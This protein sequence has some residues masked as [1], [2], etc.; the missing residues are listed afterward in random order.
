MVTQE[1]KVIMEKLLNRFSRYFTNH[2][3]IREVSREIRE[4]KMRRLDS[5]KSFM[6][7]VG[8]IVFE[9]PIS[10]NETLGNW[11]V[12]RKL[13]KLEVR[14]QISFYQCSYQVER[15]SC[16]DSGFCANHSVPFD[17]I[18]IVANMDD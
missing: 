1:N 16:G 2:G 11:G 13:M 14:P 15:K 18:E 17:I 7:V 6:G 4:E 5:Q 3:C 8:E 10:K 12:T 9:Q